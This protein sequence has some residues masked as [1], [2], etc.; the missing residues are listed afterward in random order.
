VKS[1]DVQS[2]GGDWREFVCQLETADP[3]LSD[4]LSRWQNVTLADYID[5]VW[6]GMRRQGADAYTSSFASAMASACVKR[7]GTDFSLSDQ[8]TSMPV[9]LNALHTAPVFHPIAFQT[10]LAATAGRKVPQTIPVLT[11]DWISMDSLFY[12]RGLL[13]P[14][15][16]EMVTVNLFGKQSRKKLVATQSSFNE[17]QVECTLKSVERL[18][19]CAEISPQTAEYYSFLL[20]E[21]YRDAFV[22][23]QRRYSDQCSVLN[24]SLCKALFPEFDFAFVNISDIA[25]ALMEEQLADQ[26]SLIFKLLFYPGFRLELIRQLDGI[27]ECWDTKKSLGS[28]LFWLIEDDKVEPFSF[29]CDDILFAKNYQLSLQPEK[30]IEALRA[31]TV[32]P[33]MS[34]VIIMLMF[35]FGVSCVGGVR[36]M[37]T[38]RTIQRAVAGIVGH[39]SERE[40]DRISR[41]PIEAFITGLYSEVDQAGNPL[42]LT[43]CLFN[44]GFSRTRT[45]GSTL[46]QTALNAKDILMSYTF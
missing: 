23:A 24:F 34:L 16:R 6:R 3:V 20:D 18:L 40:S 1:R 13:L 22:L 43:D 14:G 46:I 27:D 37:A 10:L 4:Y 38:A 42:I 45:Q 5:Y 7:F 12:P 32:I 25:V 44:Q 39:Y 33:G 28:I 41:L 21:Y 19:E 2:G 30:I 17:E 9:V 8:L 11:N 36:Q 35:S 15:T 29:H 26:S 31:G